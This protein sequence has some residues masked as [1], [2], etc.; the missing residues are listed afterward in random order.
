MKPRAACWLTTLVCTAA[1]TAAAIGPAP[2]EQF[3]ASRHLYDRVMV[4]FKQRDYEAAL[5]G[6]RLF[7]ELHAKSP[8]AANAQYWIGECQYKLGRYR[9]ALHSFSD[10]RSINP[11]S[12]KAA[13]SAFKVGQTYAMLGDY[14]R[15]RLSFDEVL[16]RYPGGVEAEL[17][18]KALDGMDV[19]PPQAW[20]NVAVSHIKP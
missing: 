20:T 5:A 1:L 3:D 10:V 16:D 12:T 17:A 9:E 18:R 14:Y 7:L 13:A 19:K 11:L 2:A 4:E 15:A 8:L 6:F